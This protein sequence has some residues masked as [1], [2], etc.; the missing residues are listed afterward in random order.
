VPFLW[1]GTRG[2]QVRIPPPRQKKKPAV[3]CVPVI[4]DP[5]DNLFG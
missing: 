5:L 3:D 2:S 4:G 1:F